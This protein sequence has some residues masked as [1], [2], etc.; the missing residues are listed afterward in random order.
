MYRRN[1]ETTW[2][3]LLAQPY[4]QIIFGA[5]QTGKSTL[6]RNLVPNPVLNLDLGRDLVF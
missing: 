1:I 4:V 3:S 5:R 6:L 2:Q